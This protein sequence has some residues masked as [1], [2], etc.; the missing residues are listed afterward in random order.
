M[1]VPRKTAAKS[2]FARKLRECSAARRE[3]VGD[4]CDIDSATGVESIGAGGERAAGR[5][6]VIDEQRALG[7]G[8]PWVPLDGSGERRQPL[9]AAAADLTPGAGAATA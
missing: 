4:G 2:F 1:V 9:A 6:D 5:D 7:D 8:D 3:G